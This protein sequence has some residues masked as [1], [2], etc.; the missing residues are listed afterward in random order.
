MRGGY[1]VIVPEGVSPREDW[2]MKTFTA[3][4]ELD[5]E[6]DLYVATVPGLPG[7]HT[8]AQTLDELQAN[9]R[10]VVELCLDEYEGPIEGLPRFVGTQTV[11]VAV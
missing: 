6:T 7:A 10:E 11:E 8:Q 1:A 9:L 3:Y 5:P 2:S 4:V